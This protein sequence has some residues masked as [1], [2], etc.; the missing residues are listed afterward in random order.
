MFWVTTKRH[1]PGLPGSL[2]PQSR[3]L[4]PPHPNR[5]TRWSLVP[6]SRP[7]KW[8]LTQNDDPGRR[9]VHPTLSPARAP[10][11]SDAHPPLRLHGQPPQ[12][13][14]PRPLQPAS[15][16]S[17]GTTQTAS[18]TAPPVDCRTPPVPVLRHRNARFCPNP[19]ATNLGFVMIPFAGFKPEI[20]SVPLLDP[21]VRSPFFE[22]SRARTADKTLFVIPTNI[23]QR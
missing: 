8:R 11:W 22:T 14:Q 3:D 7:Q 6:L 16:S 5:R 13:S 12:R 18:R 20:L 2:H 1:G 4:Q 17:T 21:C 10:T 15:A 19:P 23:E 9:R